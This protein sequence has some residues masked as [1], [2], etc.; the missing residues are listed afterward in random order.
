MR[1]ELKVAHVEGRIHTIDVAFYEYDMVLGDTV[2]FEGH[3]QVLAQ[4]AEDAE[5]YGHQHYVPEIK[6]NVESLRTAD[7]V[8]LWVP[9]APVVEQTTALPEGTDPNWAGEPPADT[10]VGSDGE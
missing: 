5:A 4:S 3:T 8:N 2:V 6:R 10:P 9:P 7:I 1:Y